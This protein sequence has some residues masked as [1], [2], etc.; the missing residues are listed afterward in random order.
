M[1]WDH[2][3]WFA[4]YWMP[5]MLFGLV[6]MILMMAMCVAIMVFMM[7]GVRHRHRAG[8][9]GRMAYSG[10]MGLG[11]SFD[12]F[13]ARHPESGHPAQAGG[14]P[15]FDEYRAETLRRLEREQSEF[16]EFVEHLRLAKDRAGF[17]RFIT[18]RRTSPSLPRS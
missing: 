7:R 1:W 2:Y 3:S 17:D 12:R 9:D 8:A 10:G 13:D 15:A 5:W 18:E 4:G 16:Q 11:P 14:S 6:M